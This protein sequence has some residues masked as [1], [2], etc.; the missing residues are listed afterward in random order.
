MNTNKAS[1]PSKDFLQSMIKIAKGDTPAD[2]VI[3]NTQILDVFNGCFMQGDIAIY[4][5]FIAG[6]AKSYQGKTEVAADDA[7]V[8]PG[9]IDTHVH[10]ESS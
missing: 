5:N 8:V 7:Y 10:I 6:I 9:F 2:L 4:Q 3:K 1:Y